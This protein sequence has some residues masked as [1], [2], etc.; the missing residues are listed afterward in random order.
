MH[1]H[2]KVK[3]HDHS[4]YPPRWTRDHCTYTYHLI[5]AVTWRTRQSC[6]QKGKPMHNFIICT[7]MYVNLTN[8]FNMHTEFKVLFSLAAKCYKN[9]VVTKHQG[10]NSSPLEMLLCTVIQWAAMTVLGNKV[11]CDVQ[12]VHK[13]QYW[14]NTI[15]YST[16][17]ST[18]EVTTNL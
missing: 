17:F 18:D 8:V 16:D 11:E 15:S 10:E 6:L 5:Q 9:H 12:C 4:P 1:R 7:L 13:L 2:K 3:C 14:H